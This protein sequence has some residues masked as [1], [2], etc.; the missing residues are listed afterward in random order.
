[1]KYQGVF[2]LS[3]RTYLGFYNGAD[4]W[5]HKRYVVGIENK[6]GKLTDYKTGEIYD[7]VARNEKNR[8]KLTR[9]DTEIGKDYAID[10]MV[11]FFDKNEF[12]SSK[13]INKFIINSNLFSEEYKGHTKTK[14]KIMIK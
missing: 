11:E 12:Y 6:D 7:F 3:I 14:N 10:A 9:E 4:E 13:M 2:V 5:M 1:M 8:M